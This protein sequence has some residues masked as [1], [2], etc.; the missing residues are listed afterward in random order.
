MTIEEILIPIVMF[1]I[2]ESEDLMILAD[3]IFGTNLADDNEDEL[4]QIPD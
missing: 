3:S 2:F 4:V 1:D